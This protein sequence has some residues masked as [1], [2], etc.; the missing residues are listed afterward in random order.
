[1]DSIDYERTGR[2]DPLVLLHGLGA[3]RLV[4]QPQIERLAPERDVITLDMPGFGNS[5]P[6]ADETPPTAAALGEAIAAFLRDEGIER[7]H[8]AGNSLGGWV[9][10]EMAKS[11]R[12]ASACLISPA[13]LWQTP[14]GPRAGDVRGLARRLKPLVLAAARKRSVRERMLSSVVARPG[15]V[16]AEDGMALIRAW[17][18][19]PGYEASNAEMRLHVFADPAHV[20]VPVTIAWGEHDRLVRPPRPDRRPPGARFL[21]LPDCGHTPNW[22]DADLVAEVLLDASATAAGERAA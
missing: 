11:G 20:T 2:G 6:L 13:G 1:M 18:E 14:L 9:A 15:N 4:W 7:P 5:P 19:A 22:D 12:A 17:I 16:P 8:V 10:L 3:T 21:V